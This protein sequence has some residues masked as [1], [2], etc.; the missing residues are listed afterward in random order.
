MVNSRTTGIIASTHMPKNANHPMSQP[1]PLR[2]AFKC[3]R[4]ESRFTWNRLI[5]GESLNISS[6]DLLFTADEAFLPGQALEAF[7]DWPLLLDNRVRLTLVVEGKV[8]GTAENHAA[9]RIERYQFRTRGG[10]E[11]PSD[12]VGNVAQ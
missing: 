10:V 8:V 3:R 6:T 11:S 1:Y 4:M 2:L 9:M 7:I 12:P 5:T